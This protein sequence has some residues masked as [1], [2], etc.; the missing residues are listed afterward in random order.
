MAKTPTTKAAAP[1]TAT[2]PA[3]TRQ[4]AVCEKAFELFAGY[5]IRNQGLDQWQQ[6]AES[7]LAA[8]GFVA[9]EEAY[10]RGGL[11]ALKPKA[12]PARPA[13]PT[14]PRPSE[15]PPAEQLSESGA[16]PARPSAADGG[17]PAPQEL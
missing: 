7:F 6:L 16:P 15:L 17:A 9:A 3:K 13:P 4:D 1:T 5:K 14:P 12:K 8:E 2:L 10:R 11:D